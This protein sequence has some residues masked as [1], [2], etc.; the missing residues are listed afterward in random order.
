[1]AVAIVATVTARMELAALSGVGVDVPSIIASMGSLVEV[2]L[3]LHPAPLL[4]LLEPA[5]VDLVAMVSA[6]TEPVVLSGV[7][8][9]L[10]RNI[11]ANQG[12][13]TK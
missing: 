11:V 13:M 6:L 12:I 5:E 8:A 9:A 7:G 1:M 10:P 2:L 4:L 3:C